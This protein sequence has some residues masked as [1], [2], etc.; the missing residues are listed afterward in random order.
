MFVQCNQNNRDV[1]HIV[2]DNRSPFGLISHFEYTKAYYKEKDDKNW[3]D[4]NDYY[5]HERI[6]N[7]IEE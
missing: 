6:E 1:D 3:I 7:N 4:G 5:L 2:V